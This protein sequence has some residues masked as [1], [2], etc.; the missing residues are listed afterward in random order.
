MILNRTTMCQL[1]L[2]WVGRML[3]MCVSALLLACGGGGSDG[4]SSNILPASSKS[5][6]SVS[7]AVGSSTPSTSSA[8]S[9]STS[10]SSLGSSAKSSSLPSVIRLTGKVTYDLIPHNQNHLGLNYNAGNITPGRGLLIE[11]LDS[12]NLVLATTTSD[13]AGNYA[14]TV[15][16]NKLVKIRVKAQL[17]RTQKPTWDFRVTDNTN[18]NSIYAMDGSLVAANDATAVR[19]L[20]AASGWTGVGYTQPRV[21]A[22]FAILDSVLIGAEKVLAAGNSTDFPPLELRWSVKNKA[23]EGDLALG[24]I[25]TSF[26]SGSAIYILGDENNDTDEYDRH[27]ILHEWGHYLES[28]FARSDS[29]GGDHVYGDKLDMRVAMSEGFSNAFSAMMLD[30][31]NYRDASGQQQTD[32]FTNN[33][34][35]KSHVVRGWYSEASVESVLYNFYTSSNGKLARDF[36]DIFSVLSSDAYVNNA[37][38][39]SIYVFADALRNVISPQATQFNSL[40]LEQNIEITNA[41][42]VN[43]SN[44]GGYTESLPIYKTLALNN[45]PVNVCSTNRFGAYNKLAVAQFMVLDIASAGTYQISVQEAANDSG[46][47]DPDIYLYR[48]GSLL[49]AAEGSQIDQENLSRFL[50]A[51]IYVL[52]LVDDRAINV[53]NSDEIT[54][55]FEVRAQRL[56]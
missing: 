22:P 11:L 7:I 23:A 50:S 13:N 3:L 40:L 38:M 43:E 16:I 18:G 9:L 20:H 37:A 29:I 12:D 53:D 25:G 8:S 56:N 54:A 21:A 32:G 30:D 45:T 42:G 17:L 44:S 27:V 41:F 55:C 15:E 24:E 51:G 6:S 2:A 10:G 26:Y 46:D 5:L 36:T 47:S 19:N 48:R 14:F 35:R 33:V 39:I 31:P 52:E 4:G 49:G 1:M 34:S 28:E